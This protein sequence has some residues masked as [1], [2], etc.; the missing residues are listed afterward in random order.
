MPNY[1]VIKLGIRLSESTQA[2]PWPIST[3]GDTI[4]I[5]NVEPARHRTRTP[6]HNTSYQ[7]S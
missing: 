2:I 5:G 7:R 1:Y 4:H 3:K 6:I